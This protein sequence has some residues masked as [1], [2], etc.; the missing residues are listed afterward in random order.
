[1]KA[2]INYCY[3]TYFCVALFKKKEVFSHVEM[4]LELMCSTHLSVT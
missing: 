1:M 4:G 2:H 3:Q